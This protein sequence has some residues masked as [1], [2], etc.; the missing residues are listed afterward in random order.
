MYHQF[1]KIFM[2]ETLEKLPG[3]PR[4]CPIKPGSYY[5]YD[6][7][8]IDD[9]PKNPDNQ[10]EYWRDTSG[11]PNGNYRVTAGLFTKTDPQAIFIE[12]QFEVNK[13]MNAEKF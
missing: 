1:Y 4:R 8:I 3:V 13:R 10:N 7:L 11:L 12:Y 5:T 6:A 2:D 9:L